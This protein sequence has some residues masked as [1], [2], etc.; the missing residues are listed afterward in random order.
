MLGGAEAESS[1]LLSA[2]C[3]REEEKARGILFLYALKHPFFFNGTR[4]SWFFSSVCW[5]Q[6]A[7]VQW[8]VARVNDVSEVPQERLWSWGETCS[9]L[10][11]W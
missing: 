3:M 4:R 2:M 5:W 10:L 1:S 8:V 9:V 7:V 11:S 6:A